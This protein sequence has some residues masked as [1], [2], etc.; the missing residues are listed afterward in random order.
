MHSVSRVNLPIIESYWVQPGLLLAGEYAGS[1]NLEETR[2]RLNRFMDAGIR[3][4]IDLTQPDEHVPYEQVLLQ[5]AAARKV[6]SAYH[7]F[8]IRDH[9]ICSPQTMIR[10][11]NVIDESIEKQKGVY[12]HCWGGIGRTGIVIGCY[13][14]RH[15]MESEA[16]LTLINKLYRTRPPNP[17]Y[18]R[19]P[20]TDE[21]I[22]FV[23]NW[24]EAPAAKGAKGRICEG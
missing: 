15:G 11:L 18:P 13:L 6:E 1:Y 23:R 16:A 4:F 5:Q 10:I 19:S 12:V 24:R 22:R 14:V 17:F 20:E 7:R 2:Q 8:G 3:T 21:Q 9:G